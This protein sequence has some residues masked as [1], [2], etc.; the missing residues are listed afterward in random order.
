M[1]SDL[2]EAS[3]PAHLVAAGDYYLG[4][5]SGL[6]REVKSDDPR[7][8]RKVRMLPGMWRRRICPD[9][10]E[11][12]RVEWIEAIRLMPFVDKEDVPHLKLCEDADG[13]AI[14]RAA[15]DYTKYTICKLAA[16]M[17]NMVM[18]QYP[19]MS[20][21]HW[22]ERVAAQLYMLYEAGFNL[23]PQ[24]YQLW[25]VAS[26]IEGFYPHDKYGDRVNDE[27]VSVSGG[28]VV[29]WLNEHEGA[30]FEALGREPG[31]DV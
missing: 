25:E 16:R 31:T 2:F 28:D 13:D 17:Y 3:P 19:G 11:S 27:E 24:R 21:H 14:W 10:M 26:L 9:M 15:P 30:I 1:V 20:V 5:P 7:I 12:L 8:G 4:P 22:A 23:I 29:G 6:W 18:D